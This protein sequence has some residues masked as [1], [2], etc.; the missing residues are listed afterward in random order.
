M[1]GVVHLP[2]DFMGRQI[3]PGHPAFF[4]AEAG[5]N[6]DGNLEDALQMIEVASEC[7]ADAVKFQ[8]R[9]LN[10]LYRPDALENPSDASHGIGVYMPTLKR[11]ELSEDDHL[12]L[13][14]R[15][16]LVG[17][18]YLCSP[19]DVQSMGFLHH[20]GVEAWKI[21]SAC[22][23]DIYLMRLAE[24][25]K[26]PVIF[27]TGMHT[28]A[29]VKNLLASYA[30]DFRG[31][32]AVLHC[33]SSY[34]TAERDINLGFMVKLADLGYLVG[35]SGHERGVPVTVAAVALGARIIER[36]FTLDRTRRG[37]DHAASLE[38]RGL[39][40]LIRHVRAVEESLGSV[41]IMNRGEYLARE[42]LGKALTWARDVPAGTKVCLAD[43]CA[44][45]PGHGIEPY[46]VGRFL[47]EKVR[48]DVR[49]GTL[50]K[51]EDFIEVK[52]P[53]NAATEGRAS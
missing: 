39:E 44:M 14:E 7:G 6:H 21:P 4:I 43:M 28:E 9:D 53:A 27:S 19:W 48:E 37:P 2:M 47:D 10:A 30:D 35:Y 5:I 38:P 25:T 33:V 22:L 50:V 3:G 32:M 23:S 16:D 51:I 36:H 29:E 24:V 20:L 52:Q 8:K 12:R 15:C 1:S 45:S 31:R 46:Q 11:C 49:G 18:K 41:K 42:T 17:I 34:P 26:K 40:T 13:K